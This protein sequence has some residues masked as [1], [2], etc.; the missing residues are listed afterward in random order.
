[1]GRFRHF[2]N[3][4]ILVILSTVALR[5]LFDVI[6]AL[7]MAASAEA[8][9]IDHLFNGHFWM[10]SFLFSLIMVMMIYSIF[11]FRRADGDETDGPHIHGNSKLEITWTVIPLMVVLGFGVWGAFT[12]NEI[13]RPKDGEM[14][15]NVTGRQWSWSFKYP[16]QGDAAAAELVLPVNR[17]I[18]LKMNAEDVIHS[19]W[20]PEFRVKQDLVPGRETTLRITPT[21]IG[22]YRLRCAE[23]CGQNHT[24]MEADVKVVSAEDFQAWIEQKSAGPSFADMTPEE[25][26]AY[27]AS[28][29]GFA[30][31]ACHTTDGT[32]S[33][34][35]T[36]QGLYMHNVKLADGSTTEANDEYLH[37]S[38]IDPNL[39]I[40]DG[41]LP[42]VMPGN[43]GDR[44]AEREQ[45]VGAAEGIDLDISADLIAYIKSLQ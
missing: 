24:T 7:P 41:F 11:V 28:T 8:R 5:L 12:L 16:E 30:C 31:V 27:W 44:F 10:I 18:V 36:W 15:V 19:F 6:L 1:M 32:P 37:N 25:R 33:A 22:N 3:I 29:E 39:Q 40:V 9:P 42:N 17:T 14:T 38:I 4:I 13:T 26:G 23:I 20:V 35:P 43:F 21:E 2:I 45:E 34:G